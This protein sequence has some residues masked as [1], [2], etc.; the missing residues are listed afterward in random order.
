[1][2]PQCAPDWRT[3]GLLLGVPNSS[4]DVIDIYHVSVKEKCLRMLV[5]WLEREPYATW[6]VIIAVV[7]SLENAN[8]R[9]F[10]YVYMRIRTSIHTNIK[11]AKAN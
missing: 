10:M 1:M 4:L 3:I 2:V 11:N 5:Q 7:D 6:K 8:G 9:H